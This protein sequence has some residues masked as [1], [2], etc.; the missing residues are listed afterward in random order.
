MID[1]GSRASYMV[2][3]GRRC[4]PTW[5]LVLE[6]AEYHLQ[7]VPLIKAI[8]SQFM[9]K[10]REYRAMSQWKECKLLWPLV[11]MH[12]L[13]SFP[14]Y[15]RVNSSKNIMEYTKDTMLISEIFKCWTQGAVWF[16]DNK[17]LCLEGKLHNCLIEWKCKEESLAEECWVRE[18]KNDTWY[19]IHDIQYLFSSS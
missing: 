11:P 18:C 15:K 3:W 1:Q 5:Q 7:C 4:Q 8:T 19:S 6:L 2:A 14:F 10:G 16:I 17:N 9:F 13:Y 12:A